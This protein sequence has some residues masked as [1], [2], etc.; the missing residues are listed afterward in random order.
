VTTGER[1]RFARR[2]ELVLWLAKDLRQRVDL[3]CLHKEVSTA[4]EKEIASFWAWAKVAS[5]RTNAA[6]LREITPEA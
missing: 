4:V 6:M 1:C 5:R 3:R 2:D